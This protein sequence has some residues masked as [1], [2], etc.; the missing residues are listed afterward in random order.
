MHPCEL[1]AVF[2]S[3]SEFEWVD[4]PP[5]AGTPPK[6]RAKNPLSGGAVCHSQTGVGRVWAALEPFSK[7]GSYA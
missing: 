7:Q 5:P 3:W 2:N 1:N 6:R 4:P